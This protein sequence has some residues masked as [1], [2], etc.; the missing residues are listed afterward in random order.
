M[1]CVSSPSSNVNMCSVW[2]SIILL[3]RPFLLC[4]L[5]LFKALLSDHLTDISAQMKLTWFDINIKEHQH[6]VHFHLKTVCLFFDFGLLWSYLPFIM[7]SCKRALSLVLRKRVIHWQ[8]TRSDVLNVWSKWCWTR[9]VPKLTARW[10]GPHPHSLCL[11]F[12]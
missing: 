7:G 5:L 1:S 2:F 12:E 3:Q 6:H 8:E 11:S 10:T 4:T 9:L